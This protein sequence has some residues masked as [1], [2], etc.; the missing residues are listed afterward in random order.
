MVV[1]S[2]YE[3]NVQFCIIKLLSKDTLISHDSTSDTAAQT[4]LIS[5][6]TIE[7]ESVRQSGLEQHL[8]L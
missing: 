5:H 3:E 2:F 1:Q 6:G 4:S 7:K 8:T